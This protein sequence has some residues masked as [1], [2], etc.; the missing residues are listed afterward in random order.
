M[1]VP[2]IGLSFLIGWLWLRLG[3]ASAKIARFKT[4][5]FFLMAAGILGLFVWLSRD[6]L[7][8]WRDSG[9]LWEDVL[10]RHSE[11]ALAHANLGAFYGEKDR[12]DEAIVQL[13]KAVVLDPNYAKA[14]YNLAVAYLRKNESALAMKHFE[15]ALTL[16]YKFS[17]EVLKMLESKK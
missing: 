9:T 5:V 16:G 12:L 17:P 11:V 14:H 3:A 15:R 1:Y 4:P 6:R 2:S 7:P 8:V 10:Q 13:Q